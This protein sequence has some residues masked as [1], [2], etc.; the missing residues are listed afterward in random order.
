[1]LI[2]IKD[3]PSEV[4]IQAHLFP[5]CMLCW[6]TKPTLGFP[7]KVD[8]FFQMS[9]IQYNLN[10][11]RTIYKN[12]TQIWRRSTSSVQRSHVVIGA[13]PIT[14][15]VTMKG[16][17]MEYLFMHFKISNIPSVLT[18]N[19]W[20]IVIEYQSRFEDLHIFWN[21]KLDTRKLVSTSLMNLNLKS[22]NKSTYLPWLH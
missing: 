3:K 9:L 15:W 19:I 10:W 12:Q 14:N 20:N 6:H 8:F 18:W 21:P 17:L 13:K 16:K 11:M 5:S 1:M 2:G 7:P 4:V 22:N